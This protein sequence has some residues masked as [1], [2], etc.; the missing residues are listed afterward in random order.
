[1]VLNA[2]RI[3]R[4]EGG[5]YGEFRLFTTDNFFTPAVIAIK[6]R[7]EVSA[8][9]MSLDQL[10]QILGTY[11]VKV[12]RV[13]AASTNVSNFREVLKK[14][15]SGSSEFILVNYLRKALGQESGGHISPVGAFN[16][17]ED[18]VL[19]LDV[20]NYKYP[21]VWVKIE[22]LFRAMA[23]TDEGAE[24]SRGYVVVSAMPPPGK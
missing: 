12:S 5:K 16:E 22:D 2:L 7:N 10:A 6:P 19:V 21:W 4:P 24:S 8:S 14:Q 18:L 9:G 15:L 3:P 1:M 20:S 11:P 23:S 13:Y 17:K